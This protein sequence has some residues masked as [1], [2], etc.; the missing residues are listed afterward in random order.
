MALDHSRLRRFATCSCKPVAGGLLPSLTP[1]AAAHGHRVSK[2]SPHVLILSHRTGIDMYFLLKSENI[3]GFSYRYRIQCTFREN[4]KSS[5]IKDLQQAQKGAYKP[6]YKKSQKTAGSLPQDI[7]AELA[8][9]VAIWPDLPVH[10]KAAIKALVQTTIQG[11][12]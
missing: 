4:A 7:P 3:M 6:A 9:I 1:L 12:S 5:N 11:D 10:I 2:M 8:E